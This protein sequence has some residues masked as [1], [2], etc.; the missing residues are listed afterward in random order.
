M[1][2]LLLITI[3]AMALSSCIRDLPDTAPETVTNPAYIAT[4]QKAVS[5]DVEALKQIEQCYKTG[6]NGFPKDNSRVLRCKKMLAERGDLRC[7]RELGL[8]Y[9]SG[10]GGVSKND[11]EA[12]KWLNLAAARGD[13]RAQRGLVLLRSRQAH[14]KSR[15]RANDYYRRKTAEDTTNQLLSQPI[16]LY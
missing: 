5:G 4:Y 2:K 12:N 13:V 1:K 15:D 10:T 16:F 14:E 6:T 8:A 9:L 11:A 7:Q 3:T